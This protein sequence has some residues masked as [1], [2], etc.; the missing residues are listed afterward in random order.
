MDCGVPPLPP[1]SLCSGVPCVPPYHNHNQQQYVVLARDG[2][3]VHPPAD[4]SKVSANRTPTEL[5]NCTREP[6][7]KLATQ[8]LARTQRGNIKT[9]TRRL[10]AGKNSTNQIILHPP[11]RSKLQQ[12]CC[13]AIS[14]LGTG[15]YSYRPQWPGLTAYHH[16]SNSC[17]TLSVSPLLPPPTHPAL[18]PPGEKNFLVT[19]YG[20]CKLT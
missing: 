11:L 3:L 9:A 10:R 19:W 20:I 14:H 15:W 2:A 1:S 6:V 12:F 18:H 16:Y 5:R 4:K 7:R 8:P 17:R 13:V